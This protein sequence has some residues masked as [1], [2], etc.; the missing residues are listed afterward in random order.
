MFR[1]KCPSLDAGCTLK[2]SVL[3]ASKLKEY[4][5]STKHELS[6]KKKWIDEK[7]CNYAHALNTSKL[8]IFFTNWLF[9]QV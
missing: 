6:K 8:K 2:F 9:Q 7:N 5:T 4:G 1:V 3:L